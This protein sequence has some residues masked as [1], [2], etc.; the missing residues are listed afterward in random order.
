MTTLIKKNGQAPEVEFDRDS[1]EGRDEMIQTDWFKI[2]RSG[3][4]PQF[5]VDEEKVEEIAFE[6][7][8][9]GRRPPIVFDHL[10]PADFDKNAKP[11][12]AAGYIVALRAVDED[13]P[14]FLGK[15][16]LE[17]KAKVSFWASYRTRSGEY[18]NLSVGLYKHDSHED[19]KT[20]LALHHLA[21]L[22]A[23]PPAVEGLPEVIFR[24]SIDSKEEK[25]LSFAQ[26]GYGIP[27]PRP[28]E[29]PNA[30]QRE[31][32]VETINFSE[33]QALLKAREGELTLDHQ[34]EIQTFSEKLRTAES[35]VA[36][37][38][39]QLETFQAELPTKLEQARA[40]GVEAG[41]TAASVE[42]EANF[43]AQ[44]EKSEVVVFCEGLLKTGKVNQKEFAPEGKLSMVDTILSIPAGPARESYR[45]LL[46]ARPALPG[47]PG[48]PVAAFRGEGVDPANM[49]AEEKEAKVSREAKAAVARG[50][51]KNFREAFQSLSKKEA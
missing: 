29:N 32:K 10:T 23:A 40:E 35:E 17:A 26:Q 1:D 5:E 48:A 8:Q 47:T 3:D 41:K 9:S 11:G 42:A 15:K 6:F 19:G 4:Y 36:T 33:H 7:N 25:V 16:A 34:K 49:T 13:D 28:T 18:R 12:A 43:K 44:T 37:F 27:L 20:R 2:F 45:E 22:G 21:L 24:E 39:S 30:I 51:F 38:R 31:S 50:E 46:S 14:R